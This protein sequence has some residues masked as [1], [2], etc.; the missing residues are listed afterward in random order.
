MLY[1]KIVVREDIGK[2]FLVFLEFSCNIL[3]L[4]KVKIMKI[5]L[6]T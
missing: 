1:Y 5:V 6:R 3:P 4:Q 2:I